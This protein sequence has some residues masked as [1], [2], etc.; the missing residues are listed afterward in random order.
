MNSRR[1]REDARLS[2]ALR[3][4]E[5][6]RPRR[7][8]RALAGYA[9]Y[10][11]VRRC[12]DA[13]AASK[14]TRYRIAEIRAG[15]GCGAPGPSPANLAAQVRSMRAVLRCTVQARR[16]ATFV[17]ERLW[18]CR[19]GMRALLAVMLELAVAMLRPLSACF[20]MI[21]RI[22]LEPLALAHASH[23][24]PSS[25]P[26]GDGRSSLDTVAAGARALRA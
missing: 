25:L 16:L 11:L 20:E 12:V 15:L 1:A 10:P 26:P 2:V 24:P 23:A 6:G 22:A 8:H 18:A 5:A 19:P 4:A 7:L 21:V 14:S 3:R 13:L 9:P 17:A